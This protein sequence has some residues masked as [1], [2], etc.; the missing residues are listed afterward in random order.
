MTECPALLLLCYQHVMGA[1]TAGFTVVDPFLPLA[2]TDA[3]S[4]L[5]A[6]DS[7]S[8]LLDRAFTASAPTPSRGTQTEANGEGRG[9]DRFWG[10]LRQTL[11][12]VWSAPAMLSAE[13]GAYLHKVAGV[14]HF[15]F[16]TTVAPPGEGL[17]VSQLSLTNAVETSRRFLRSVTTCA[18]SGSVD[19]LL[20]RRQHALSS[21]LQYARLVPPATGSGSSPV[22]AASPTS[23]S[24][25][26]AGRKTARGEDEGNGDDGDSRTVTAEGINYCM[27]SMPQQW[28]VLVSGA[29]DRVLALAQQTS[30]PTTSSSTSAPVGG[31]TKPYL[32]QLLSVLAVMDTTRFMYAFPDRSED[33][34][35]YQLLARLAEVGV[36]YPVKS[37]NDLKCFVLSPHYHHALEWQ[38]TAPL[39]LSSMLGKAD[40]MPQGAEVAAEGADPTDMRR[41]DQDTIITETNF[42]LY[43]Y[44]RNPDLLNILDQFAVRE[45]AVDGVLVCYRVTR[46]SFAKALRQGISAG[47]VLKFLSLRAHPSMLRQ[48]GEDA[49]AVGYARTSSSDAEGGGGGGGRRSWRVSSSA[50]GSSSS[51][52]SSTG[53][54][55]VPQSFCDQLFMWES[56]CNRVR[57]MKHVVLLRNMTADQQ[58]VVSQF[59]SDM[60]E[61]DAVV[62]VEPGFMVVTEEVY[63]RLLAS[64]V[65]EVKV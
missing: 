48:Y 14:P 20:Q 37:T 42:R 51:S 44:T 50:S 35:G 13:H 61:A 60:G 47:Q 29:V 39:C 24:S 65:D 36:V 57:F 18:L 64:S 56:E 30:Q 22:S 2:R 9:G 16:P 17:P 25:H 63:D 1:L 43:A 3:V 12:V 52:S 34:A 23:S 38:A 5:L 62:Y 58:S 59:L 54:M 6:M 33:E 53:V 15:T 41:E 8:A 27:M 45:E 32:W 31:I 28:W 7:A 46:Q 21:I 11:E 4:E 49:H 40:A 10:T 19:Y 55:T 26:I